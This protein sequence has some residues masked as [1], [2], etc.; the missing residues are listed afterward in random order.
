MKKTAIDH[1]RILSFG[2]S[3]MVAV[4]SAVIMLI[5]TLLLTKI[6]GDAKG[7]V[8]FLVSSL[9]FA[10][11]V[12]VSCFMICRNDPVSAW[13][14][15]VICNLPPIIFAIVDTEIWLPAMWILF[16]STILLS[17]AGAIIGARK[18]LKKNY[19]S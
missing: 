3:L 7:E 12:A 4:I 11:V 18:G 1:S 10:A 19:T 15:P 13:Y 9:V 2:L 14:V 8:A 5:L 6:L 16:G 17:V